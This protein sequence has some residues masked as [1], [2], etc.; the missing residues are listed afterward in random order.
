MVY[1][2]RTGEYFELR[3]I[4]RENDY[5]LKEIKP[6]TLRMLWFTSP[7]SI[8]IIDGI[9]YEFKENEIVFLT[10]FHNVEYGNVDAVKMLRFN[11]PFYC[12]LDHDSEVGCKGVLYYG[13]AKLPIIQ[14]SGVELEI[15][16]TVWKMSILEFEMKDNLQQEMLQ[17]MLKRI[18]ILCTRIYMKQYEDD[19]LSSKQH[20]LIRDFN[21]LVETNF[22]TKHAVADYAT[23]LHK[24][25]K[26]ISNVFKKNGEKSPLKFIQERI[27]LEARR[28]I[29]YT[30][31]QISEIAYEL[32][33]SDIQSFSRFFKKHED[34]SPSEFREKR[35]QE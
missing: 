7:N 11:R 30:E 24:S 18:L 14:V 17:M 15:L 28:L 26:T 9:P 22:K 16:N 6:D 1:T 19:L 27:M 25:P 4:N 10:Q 32:G 29:F 35:G 3:N 13:A 8:L 31:K 2:G 23:L 20:D 34:I 12:I 33:F 21:F 5:H